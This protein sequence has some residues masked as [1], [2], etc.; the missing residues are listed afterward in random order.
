MLVCWERYF[1]THNLVQPV[2][3]AWEW[4]ANLDALAGLGISHSNTEVGRAFAILQ[5]LSCLVPTKVSINKVYNLVFCIDE[6]VD[7][8]SFLHP[9]CLPPRSLRP[10]RA[11][12]VLYQEKNSPSLQSRHCLTTNC[13]RPA[14][15]G[16]RFRRL[17]GQHRSYRNIPAGSSS[18]TCHR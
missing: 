7:E 11:S 17:R 10:P 9:Q 16:G 15:P 3:L 4:E 1:V 2:Y 14:G 13:T 18:M 8:C 5:E 6:F 12:T